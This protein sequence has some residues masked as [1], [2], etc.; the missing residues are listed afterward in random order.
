MAAPDKK[1]EELSRQFQDFS[2]QEGRLKFIVDS[3]GLPADRIERIHD[4]GRPWPMDQVFKSPDL[5]LQHKEFADH[6]QSIASRSGEELETVIAVHEAYQAYNLRLNELVSQV[7]A[8][9]TELDA[10]QEGST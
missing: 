8:R 1:L 10:P 7:I 6:L 3:T 9:R 5:P 4:L 2:Q